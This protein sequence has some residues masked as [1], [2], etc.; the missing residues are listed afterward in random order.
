MYV[1]ECGFIFF[2]RIIKTLVLLI[3]AF[4]KGTG[5][6]SQLIIMDFTDNLYTA[7][8]CK[9]AIKYHN[10]LIQISLRCKNTFGLSFRNATLTQIPDNFP[11]EFH[12]NP[13]DNEERFLQNLLRK[14][15]TSRKCHRGNLF[16]QKILALYLNKWIEIA[17]NNKI[18]KFNSK[19]EFTLKWEIKVSK[20]KLFSLK[21]AI[22]Y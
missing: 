14:V 22:S 19:N 4:N 10:T 12:Q 13:V 21:S 18:D 8:K 9:V 1:L 20:T 2:T 6:T 17:I 7:V 11:L 16:L 15:R 5:T 3:I